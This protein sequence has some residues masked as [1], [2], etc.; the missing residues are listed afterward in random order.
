MSTV[1]GGLPAARPRPFVAI[2]TTRAGT[3]MPAQPHRLNLA[4]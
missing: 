1:H 4:P 3:E 2:E